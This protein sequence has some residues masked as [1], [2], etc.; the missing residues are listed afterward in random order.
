VEGL[1]VVGDEIGLRDGDLVGDVAR[2]CQIPCA[3]LV[4]RA[5]Q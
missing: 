1:I 3:F 5:D 4:L 2:L